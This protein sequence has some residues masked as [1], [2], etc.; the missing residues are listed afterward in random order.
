MICPLCTYTEWSPSWAGSI[1][2]RGKEYE[3]RRCL[4]CGS[5]YSYPMPDAETLALMYGTDYER[6]LS[7][8][9]SMSGV[10]GAGEVIRWL[11][12]NRPGTFIDYGCGAGHLLREAAKRGW[13]SVGVELD[14]RI[15]EKYGNG[16]EVLIVTDPAKLSGER[17]A[18]VLHLGDVIEHLTDPDAQIPHILSLLKKGGILL[19]QGPLEANPN[20]FLTVMRWARLLRGRRILE[21]P[22]Y[23]VIQATAGGQRAFFTR[24]GLVELAFTIHEVSW[25]APGRLAMGDLLNPRAV[26]L[27]SV[28]CVSQ[29]VSG[30]RPSVLG[31]RYFYAGRWNG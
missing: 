10:M 24:F 6:F 5:L 11:G 28:R 21:M 20:L 19:A 14:Q 15:A 18:D 26:A 17:K 4:S 2:Y 16:A 7:A 31:N 12:L 1:S 25:P 30:F 9:E 22:P 8:E 13:R 3:Y 29:F 27:F 23:H